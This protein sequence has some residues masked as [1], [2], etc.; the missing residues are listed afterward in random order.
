MEVKLLNTLF[1][2]YHAN[3]NK[4]KKIIKL[5]L[6]GKHCVMAGKAVACEAGIP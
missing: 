1:Q 4:N 6:W 3:L 2:P 5:L